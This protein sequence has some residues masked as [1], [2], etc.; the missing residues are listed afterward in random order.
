MHT[1]HNGRLP[2]AFSARLRAELG[3]VQ[4]ERIESSMA[5]QKDVAYWLNPLRAGSRPAIGH[6][7]PGVAGTF[8]CGH[9]ER[10]RLARHPAAT[11]GRIYLLNPSS[12]LAVQALDPQP[13]EALLDIAAAP[14]GKTVLA[15]ARMANAGAITAVEPIKA[16]YFRLCANLQR[17]GVL[18]ARCRNDDGRSMGRTMRD[19][20]DRVLLDAPC[21]SEARFRINDAATL[22][23]WSPR[24]VKEAARK[25]RGLIRAAFRCLRPGGALVYC[26]C[27]Y[28][29]RENE[30]VVAYLLRREPTAGIVPL[31][32]EH[33]PT[34]PGGIDGTVRILPN[35]LF[36]GFFVAR[37]TKRLGSD[38]GH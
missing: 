12:V 27:A 28:S 11:A 6:A 1:R 14:G 38:V 34:M 7:V 5:A 17:C 25:Q 36:D 18:N 3:T 9:A 15:A 4:A 32:F 29:R 26:T 33:V 35:A 23:Y 31:R 8:A 20:C 10:D 37:L 22:R 2:A 24:K 16:R 30:A 21:S 19:S 13:G